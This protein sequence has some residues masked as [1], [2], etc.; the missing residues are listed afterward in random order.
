MPEE[1]N[2]GYRAPVLLR[3]GHLN[4]LYPH[5]FRRVN[6]VRYERTRI[7]T[8]DGDFLDLDWSYKG[9][10]R[11]AII[12][13]GLEGDSQRAYV[14]GMARALNRAGWDSCSVNL[15]GCSGEMNRMPGSYHSGSTEDLKTVVDHILVSG[16]YPVL[17]L[18][19]FSLGG[20]IT[21]RYLGEQADALPDA[22]SGAVAISVPV[23]L[24]GSARQMA[25][26]S[27]RMYMEYFLR[28]LRRKLLEKQKRYP[29]LINLDGYHKIKTFYDFDDRYTAQLHGYAN[30]DDYYRRAS[31]LF[32]LNNIRVPA[33]LLNAADDPFL[34]PGC[35]PAD[36]ASTNPWF[37]LETAEYGGHVGF[38][39]NNHNGTY[40]SEQRSVAFLDEVLDS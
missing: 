30:A 11:L 18:V 1:N 26:L 35:F 19:G 29:G 38:V 9:C 2:I 6:G 4:T 16:R 22:I 28:A 15:R 5:F 8:P 7:D 25:S 24:A 23:D 21:L 39:L 14:L 40:W 36:A 10:E 37:H 34:S 3:N 20:N 12:L 27:C 17:A 32:V 31:S 33:L 13:H